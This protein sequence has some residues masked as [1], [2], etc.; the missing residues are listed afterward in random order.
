MNAG[1]DRWPLHTQ[2]RICGLANERRTTGAALE[3]ISSDPRPSYWD[4]IHE[5]HLATP[6]AVRDG[7]L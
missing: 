3:K 1:S 7:D 5:D 6:T 4:A 2:P